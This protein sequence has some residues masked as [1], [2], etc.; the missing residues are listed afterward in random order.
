MNSNAN[1]TEASRPGDETASATRR[2]V[3]RVAGA[4]TV[5][6]AIASVVPATTA[7]QS[8]DIREIDFRDGTPPVSDGPQGRTEVVFH[9]HGY[10]QSG[11]SVD[12][13]AQFRSN[14]RELGYGGTVAA[15]TWD[16]FGFPGTAEGNARDTGD[17]FAGWL[18]DFRAENPETTIRLLGY[19]MGGIVV[20]EAVAGIDGAFTLANAD[21][22][23]SYEVSSAPCEGAGFYDAIANSCEGMHNYWSANDWIARLGSAGGAS[24]TDSETPTN[25]HDVD[26]SEFVASHSDYKASPGCIQ[27]ILDNY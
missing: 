22:I 5:A 2:D 1:S 10:T 17:A 7:A 24:C 26:V 9:A 25:Y 13:A 16:D 4:T 21:T 15:V 19:S 11:N 18:Q 6:S 20:M 23:G 12:E 27:A 8:D 3:L 14:A